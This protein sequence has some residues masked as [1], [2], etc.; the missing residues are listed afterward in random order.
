MRQQRISLLAAVAAALVCGCGVNVSVS[1]NLPDTKFD[2]AVVALGRDESK[3]SFPVLAHSQLVPVSDLPL[4][5]KA[6]VDP[7]DDLRM[8]VFFHRLPDFAAAVGL[9]ESEV[10]D[11]VVIEASVSGERLP[12]PAQSWVSSVFSTEAPEATFDAPAAPDSPAAGIAS[13]AEFQL[14]YTITAL[15]GTDAVPLSDTGPGTDSTMSTDSGTDANMGADSSMGTD[16]AASDAGDSGVAALGPFGTASAIMSISPAGEEATDPAATSDLLELFF[17][18]PRAGGAGGRDIW[19]STRTSTS[20]PW[21]APTNVSTLNTSYED[22]MPTLTGDG[23][24]IFF[25][26]DRPGG[27]GN[28]DVWMSTRSSRTSGWSGPGVVTELN[29]SAVETSP[30]V[31]RDG[32]RMVFASDRAGSLDIRDLWES[33]RPTPTGTWSAPVAVTSINT[34]SY[35]WSPH[36]SPGGPAHLV[37]QQPFGQQRLRHL[38][39]IPSHSRRRVGSRRE[40][41][42]RQFHLQRHRPVPQ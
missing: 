24:T 19:V 1:L 8:V 11:R 36:E 37:R 20:L 23:L 41:G 5:L 14:R 15:P 17:T 40:R 33:N 28:R 4:T 30:H 26:S 6:D 31:S 39:R 2:L 25:V 16:A 7:E 34:S 3:T 42:Q 13:L 18:S 32:L 21:G 27:M 38:G 10:L 9:S 29:T 22:S 35:E 12:G